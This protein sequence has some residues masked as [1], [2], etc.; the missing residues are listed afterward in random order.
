MGEPVYK[1]ERGEKVK[2]QYQIN[3]VEEKNKS[4]RKWKKYLQN[5]REISEIETQNIEEYQKERDEH[6]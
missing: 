1:E 2:I 4:G 5:T 3:T 6:G